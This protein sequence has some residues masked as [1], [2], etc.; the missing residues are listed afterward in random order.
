MNGIDT[1]NFNVI[2]SLRLPNQGEGSNRKVN[3]DEN[4]EN[5]RIIRGL[6][7]RLKELDKM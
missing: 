6:E 7:D 5:E 1:R 3:K 2:F 4:T